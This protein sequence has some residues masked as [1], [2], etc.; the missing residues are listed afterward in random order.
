MSA[1]RGVRRSRRGWLVALVAVALVAVIAFGGVRLPTETAARPQP[2]APSLGRTGSVCTV[3]GAGAG[4][5][6][7]PTP[8]PT[9][10]PTPGAAT[11]GDQSQPF[12]VAAVNVR[13]GSGA[14]PGNSGSLT[15]TVLGGSDTSTVIDVTATGAGQLLRRPKGSLVLNAAGVMS[16]TSAG[17]VYSDTDTGEDRGLQLGPCVVPGVDQWLTGLGAA[18]G[19]RSDLVL[20]NPDASDAE[21]DLRIYGEDGPVSAAGASGLTVPANDSLTVS[22]ADLIDTAG[23]I[24]VQ[25]RASAGRV[26]VMAQDVRSSGDD[27]AGADFHPVS[28]RPALQQVIPGIPGGKG[29]RSL[30]LVNP[31]QRRATVQIGVL[32]PNGAFSPAGAAEIAVPAQSTAGIDLSE[33]LA[34][35]IGTV[36]LVSDQPV[37]AAVESIS[38]SSD[39]AEDIAVSTAQPHVGRTSVAPLAIAADTT[40]QLAIGNAGRSAVTVS[41]QLFSLDGVSLYTEDVPIAPRST[42]SRQLT[43]PAPAYLVLRVPARADVYAG[44]ALSSVQDTVAGLAA[45]ALTSP[46]LTGRSIVVRSEPQV[47]R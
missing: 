3:P 26:A 45:A 34:A 6:A 5:G 44:I 27:P 43:Q 12:Q 23:S 18:E 32:G 38:Q 7:S 24:A 25:V 21:V 2:L 17:A 30:E 22:L 46:D 19:L 20:T 15:A 39:S 37:T 4:A 8:T 47:A 10:S 42:A 9:P 28:T 36:R 11:T 41:L 16:T 1:K 29:A 40:S 31:G 33:G 13:Q 14:S 35:Q